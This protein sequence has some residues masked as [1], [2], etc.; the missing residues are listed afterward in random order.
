MWMYLYIY[1]HTVES[2]KSKATVLHV[3]LNMVHCFQKINLMVILFIVFL[4][5][6]DLVHLHLGDFTVSVIFAWSTSRDL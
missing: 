3:V 6:E 4:K 1:S 2:Q 5:I